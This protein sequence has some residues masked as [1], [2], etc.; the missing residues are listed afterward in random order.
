MVKLF[1]EISFTDECSNNMVD[2]KVEILTT[3]NTVYFRLIIGNSTYDINCRDMK[4]I[5]EFMRIV[6][7]IAEEKAF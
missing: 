1:G 6:R 4:T 3:L 2:M 7:P 5:C